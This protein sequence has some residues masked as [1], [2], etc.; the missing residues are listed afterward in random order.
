MFALRDVVDAEHFLL[1]GAI[2]LFVAVLT[3][4]QII[5]LA[6]VVPEL[7]LMVSY[8]HE[9]KSVVQLIES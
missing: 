5:A 2:L 1:V 9:A 6:K 3:L 7:I 4:I 8:T